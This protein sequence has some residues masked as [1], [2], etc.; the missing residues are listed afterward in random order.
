MSD[1]ELSITTIN[2]ASIVVGLGLSIFGL[3]F[4]LRN[5]HDLNSSPSRESRIA[6]ENVELKKADIRLNY[7]L[8]RTYSADTNFIGGNSYE[9]R[10]TNI[11]KKYGCIVDSE[12]TDFFQRYGISLDS[13][14]MTNSPPRL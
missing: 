3:M 2:L 14:E 9:E 8:C 12:A 7:T 4:N 1:N 6:E 10:V 13:P 5:I 11:L